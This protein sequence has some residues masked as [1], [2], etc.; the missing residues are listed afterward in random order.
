MTIAKWCGVILVAVMT[1]ACGA[2]SPTGPGGSGASQPYNETQSGTV[3]AFGTTY[4]PLTAARSGQMTIM[5]TVNTSADL[6]LYLTPASCRG[7]NV[8]P[9]SNC[10]MLAVSDR[11]GAGAESILRSVT[12]G[13][14][15]TMWVDN[16]SF[17]P[18]NYTLTVS[19]Q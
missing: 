19:I 12:A 5:L 11:P 2:K 6:D 9:P 14:Q 10:Q 16:F 7:A 1:V 13:E 3:A 8:Y 18:Q 15:F 17:N 4:H